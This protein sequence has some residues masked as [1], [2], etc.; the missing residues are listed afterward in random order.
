MPFRDGDRMTNPR[1]LGYACWT[2]GSEAQALVVVSPSEA[3]PSAARGGQGIGALHSTA[4]AGEPN[5]WGPGGGKGAPGYG[6]VGRKHGRC[7]GTGERVNETTTDSDVGGAI[8]A[9]GIHFPQPPPRPQLAAGGVPADPQGRCSRRGRTDG[10]RLRVAPVGQPEV[11]PGPCQVRH[12]LGAAGAAGA[13][14]ERDGDRNPASGDSDESCILPSLPEALG[15][16]SL[17]VARLCLGLRVAGC[18]VT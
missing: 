1:P 14:P 5:P 15:M 3:Q 7:S 11:A 9:A 16:E 13:D 8:P 17:P 12:V 6:A 4:E 10:R 18:L 2:G